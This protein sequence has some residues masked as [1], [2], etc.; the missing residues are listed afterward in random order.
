[1]MRPF[2]GQRS[3]SLATL[4]RCDGG[5]VIVPVVDTSSREAM[6]GLSRRL[7]TVGSCDVPAG[8][9]LASATSED[10]GGTDCAPP[11]T[12][13]TVPVRTPRGSLMPFASC[14]SAAGTP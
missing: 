12:L 5:G 13:S 6:R 14:S 3:L 9:G 10:G 7:I 1:M 11:G 2:T 8:G 4:P